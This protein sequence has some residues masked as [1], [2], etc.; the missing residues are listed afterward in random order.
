M[1]NYRLMAAALVLIPAVAFGAI[2]AN[3]R[4]AVGSPGTQAPAV[5]SGGDDVITLGFDYDHSQIG[6]S[7]KHMVIAT[8]KGKFREFDGQIR[9]DAEN[10]ENSTINV[11]IDVASVDTENEK[12]DDHLRSPEFFDV[13]QFPHMSFKSVRIEAQA[14]GFVA[15]GD[16]TIRDVTRRIEMP[17]ELLGPVSAMGQTRYAAEASVEINRKDFG[18]NWNMALDNGGLVVSDKVKIEIYVELL[19]G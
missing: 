11:T 16:L 6:F 8:V 9:Y 4:E 7:V 17:F 3:S 2:N 18:V 12:R 13:E 14:D 19:A 10:P 1:K 5:L 15:V